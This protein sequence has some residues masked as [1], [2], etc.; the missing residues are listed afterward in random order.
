MFAETDVIEQLVPVKLPD[1]KPPLKGKND[2]NVEDMGVPFLYISLQFT[3]PKTS[4]L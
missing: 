2:D 3:F 4:N 1:N